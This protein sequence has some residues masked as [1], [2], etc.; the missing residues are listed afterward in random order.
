MWR[1]V[2]RLRCIRCRDPFFL[3]PTIYRNPLFSLLIAYWLTSWG[4]ILGTRDWGLRCWRY[5]RYGSSTRSVGVSTPESS[6]TTS[7]C[8]RAFGKVFDSSHLLPMWVVLLLLAPSGCYV[9]FHFDSS[10][11]RVHE[12]PCHSCYSRATLCLCSRTPAPQCSNRSSGRGG[13]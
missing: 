6:D 7:G 11:G 10:L 8:T 2:V 9:C 5:T 1:W 3:I 13:T 12:E 4:V